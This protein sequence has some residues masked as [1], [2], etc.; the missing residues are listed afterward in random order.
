MSID[1]ALKIRKVGAPVKSSGRSDTPVG[2]VCCAGCGG[3]IRSDAA[4]GIEWIRTRR[5]TEMFFHRRCLKTGG[6]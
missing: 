5:G 2:E 1:I 3:S 4:S 6:D